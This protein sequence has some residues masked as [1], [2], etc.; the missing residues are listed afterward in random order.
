[1]RQNKNYPQLLIK[2]SIKHPLFL[3]VDF[4][5]LVSIIHLI[6]QTKIVKEAFRHVD[7]NIDFKMGYKNVI[8]IKK[9]RIVKCINELQQIYK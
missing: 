2:I 4:E 8:L 3:A 1:M 5:I 9:M 7:R 6:G